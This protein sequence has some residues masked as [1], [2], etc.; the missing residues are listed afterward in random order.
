MIGQSMWRARG[1]ALASWS[2]AVSVLAFVVGCSSSSGDDNAAGGGG[3]HAGG[4]SGAAGHAGVGAGGS[5]GHGGTASGGTSGGAAGGA[6]G[7]SAGAA[8][9]STGGASGGAGGESGGAG[10]VAA[11]TG[12]MSTGGA[13]GGTAGASGGSAGVGGATG[14]TGG[15]GGS[16]GGTG[17]STAGTGGASA[18]M[19]GTVSTGGGGAGGASAGAGGTLS[20]GGGGAGG[21][22]AGAGG[23]SGGG[24]GAG[25]AS[26]S[27]GSAAVDPDGSI[28]TG[29]A[30]TAEILGTAG[31]DQNPIDLFQT[32]P[33]DQVLVG[34]NY[35][36]FG[37]FLSGFQAVCGKLTVTKTTQIN[38]TVT[39]GSTLIALG[40][41]NPATNG[42]SLCPANRVVVGFNGTV[43]DRIRKLTLTCAPVVPQFVDGVETVGVDLDNKAALTTMVPG[44][45]VNAND[46]ALTT[47]AEGQLARGM[48]VT[49]SEYDNTTGWIEGFSLVCGSASLTFPNGAACTAA[50]DCDS[51]TCDTT[52]K[53]AVCDAPA[54]CTCKAF[55]GKNYAFCPQTAASTEAAAE[56]TC[57]TKAMHLAWVPD[58]ATEG[59]LRAAS[60]AA[61]VTDDAW[62][63]ITDLATAGTFANEPG[64]GTPAFLSWGAGNYGT[65]PNCLTAADCGGTI[66]DCV[67][68][69]NDGA[70]NNVTCGDNRPFICSN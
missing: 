8:G 36:A 46:F 2:G 10:G 55:E 51:R 15:T 16:T 33:D 6:G 9:T 28:V 26:G 53:A 43:D 35:V 21:A 58:S 5:A 60:N 63:G 40:G 61:G 4:S 39:A 31:G 25:G 17:G 45:I 48:K 68:L 27:G 11:G 70:W 13:S 47:C 30:V 62:L 59:W 69:R 14:G 22:S 1:S 42:A 20:S 41:K 52:C 34:L 54:G 50:T 65:E 23:K 44:T 57:E 32:C 24:G 66:E 67:V 49:E 56:T 64:N 7:S 19:G 38:I 29:S 3:S 37:D 12:G 18:G